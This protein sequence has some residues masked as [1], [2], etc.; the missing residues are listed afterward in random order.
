[1]FFWK[2]LSTSSIKYNLKLEANFLQTF[3][4]YLTIYTAQQT[5]Q[6]TKTLYRTSYH[7]KTFVTKACNLVEVRPE[8]FQRR[9]EKTSS[10]NNPNISH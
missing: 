5:S 8:Y 2:V 6:E 9:T 4:V 1:M 3:G 7:T 10:L